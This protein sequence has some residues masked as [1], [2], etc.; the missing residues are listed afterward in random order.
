MIDPKEITINGKTY[1]I[2]DLLRR[3]ERNRESINLRTGHRRTATPQA[4]MKYALAERIWQAQSGYAA[5]MTRY[6]LTETQAR[7]MHWQAKEILS[8]LD[9]D[10]SSKPPT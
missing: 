6:N 7:G 3:R 4:R 8:K 9:I 5:I 2:Q 10:V 1:D